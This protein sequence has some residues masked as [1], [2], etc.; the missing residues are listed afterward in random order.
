MRHPNAVPDDYRDK[1][2]RHRAHAPEQI[3]PRKQLLDSAKAQID[4]SM[5]S[6]DG[7]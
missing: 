2:D 1:E 6:D 5:A 4:L 3:A 7:G